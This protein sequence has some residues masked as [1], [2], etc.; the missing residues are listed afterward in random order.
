MVWLRGLRISRN[1]KGDFTGYQRL[2]E[3][4]KREKKTAEENGISNYVNQAQKL[5]TRGGK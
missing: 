1:L 3:R 2:L 4:M 5:M